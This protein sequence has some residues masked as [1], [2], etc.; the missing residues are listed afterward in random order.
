MQ[1]F[2][3]I[4]E[5]VAEAVQRRNSRASLTDNERVDIQIIR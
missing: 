5:S 3:I 2:P 4:I 1:I